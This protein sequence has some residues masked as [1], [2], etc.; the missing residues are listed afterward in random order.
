MNKSNPSEDVGLWLLRYDRWRRIRGQ[1]RGGTVEVIMSCRT[2]SPRP[3]NSL[4]A[5]VSEWPKAPARKDVVVDTRPMRSGHIAA[6]MLACCM[7]N[8]SRRASVIGTMRGREE[9]EETGAWTTCSH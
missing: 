5:T 8:A 9:R 3:T 1:R 2:P 7:S 6:T 4:E